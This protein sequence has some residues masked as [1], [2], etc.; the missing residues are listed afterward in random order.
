MF[1]KVTGGVKMSHSN[2]E[3]LGEKGKLGMW[4]GLR[5][6]KILNGV[7]LTA[8]YISIK[9][10]IF[11]LGSLAVKRRSLKVILPV[12]F[13]AALLAPA[14][15]KA[16]EMGWPWNYYGLTFQ[17]SNESGDDFAPSVASNDQIYLIL[18][19]RRT[20]S[21]YDVYG[22]RVTKAGRLF[23]KDQGGFPICSAQ[24]DQ[25]FPKAIWDGRNFFVVWEDRRSGVRWDL[26]GTWVTADGQV[27]VPDGFPIA[28]GRL[29]N[30]YVSP[31]LSF[32]GENYLVVW[33]GKRLSRIYNLYFTRISIEGEILDD[34]PV[35]ISP[36]LRDQASPSV[37]FD[38]E[39]YMVVWQD[40]R[41]GTFWDIYGARISPDGEVIDRKA[42]PI[43]IEKRESGGNRWKPDIS[44]NGAFY[45]LVW[46]NANDLGQG[47]LQGK[48]IG[49]TGEIYDLFGFVLQ[50]NN[51]TAQTFPAIAWDGQDH[52][53]IWEDSREGNNQIYGI[54]IAADPNDVIKSE[55]R[56]VS[57]YGYDNAAYPAVS[58]NG[59]GVLVVWQ[60]TGPLGNWNVYG[61]FL[62]R[63]QVSGK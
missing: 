61:Q 32:D 5:G 39:N 19:T 30:D 22:A 21:G 40:K 17:I 33:Q 42:I 49:P 29:T 23:E 36:S 47:A 27:T 24:N 43:S 16:Q 20:E 56:L 63:Y 57:I 60:A 31:C 8:L 18:W 12:L 38:G 25:M 62:H 50:D 59:E 26:Y 45:Y 53:L 1:R 15:A 34:R 48:R 35:P 3:V 4:I 54:S 41:S 2:Q 10:R 6:K 44:W 28:T 14:S 55:R 7:K 11:V 52:L 13:V 9:L 58:S 46:V 37:A 51:E